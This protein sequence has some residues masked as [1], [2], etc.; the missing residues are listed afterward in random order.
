MHWTWPFATTRREAKA[1][2]PI[3]LVSEPRAASWGGRDAGALIRDGY[4]CNAVAYRCV[5]MVAEAAASIPLK[6]ADPDAARLIGRPAPELS[7]TELLEAV[8][9][10]LLLTGNAFIE[11]ARLAGE[12]PIAALFPV[13]A[14][15]VRPVLDRR[16]WAEAWRVRGQSGAE[17]VIARDDEGWCALLQVRFYH[18]GEDVMGLPPLA[19]ARRA[20]DLHNASADWAKALIDNA[21][22]P[23]GALVYGGSPMAPE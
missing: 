22:K 21:A 17:C 19:A 23:S 16:G 7:A 18:P 5:R 14:G 9:S 15:T 1:T 3:A 6:S 8:Y 11:A 12:E 4:L 13:R 10:D 20:L 2:W